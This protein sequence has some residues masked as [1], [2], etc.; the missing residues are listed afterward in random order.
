MKQKLLI[1]GAL[2]RRF[3]LPMQLFSPKKRKKL[4]LEKGNLVF[5]W[6]F[7]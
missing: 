2:L 1:I 5:L 6:V 4:L 3:N 7:G